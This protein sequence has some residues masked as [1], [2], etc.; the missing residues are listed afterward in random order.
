M[1]KEDVL[2]LLTGMYQQSALP[3]SFASEAFHLH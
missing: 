1:T 3:P 2:D